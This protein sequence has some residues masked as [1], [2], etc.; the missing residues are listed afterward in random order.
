MSYGSVGCFRFTCHD[1]ACRGPDTRSE[2][3]IFERVPMP[4]IRSRYS[5]AS[6]TTTKVFMHN[7]SDMNP[8]SEHME[9]DPI[10]SLFTK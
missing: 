2:C 6:T 9:L 3:A 7:S 4:Y 1:F 8:V 10:L 5:S